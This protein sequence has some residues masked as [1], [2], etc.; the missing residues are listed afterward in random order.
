[1]QLRAGL[2][3][4]EWRQSVAVTGHWVAVSGQLYGAA[5]L[6]AG[7]EKVTCV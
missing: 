6:A 5:A 1:M 7:K 3:A 2:G 4:V